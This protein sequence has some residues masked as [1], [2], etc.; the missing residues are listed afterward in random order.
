MK[1]LIKKYVFVIILLT[2]VSI[3]P[4]KSQNL[5]EAAPN[6]SLETLS[7]DTFTLSDHRDKLV[8]IFLFGYACPHCIANAPNTESG[9]YKMFQSDT[10]FIAIGIDTW[11]GS[12]NSVMS[13]Q[14]RTGLTYEM[15]INGSSVAS[16]YATTYD[17]ILVIDQEG[18][19]RYK[20]TSN[21][22]N[23]IVAQAAEVIEFLL[24][25]STG[26]EISEFAKPEPLVYPNPVIDFAHVQTDFQPGTRVFINLV[27][28]STG[29]LLL[30]ESKESDLS[31]KLL[32]GLSNYPSGS[33]YLRVV[34]EKKAQGARILISR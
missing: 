8:F 6:F 7:G 17:R 23:N 20:S 28:I 2:I 13:F 21:A 9:I 22:T 11:N 16:V 3:A 24:S 29:R 5:G 19:L 14:N 27:D 26:I 25:P 18:I 12:P 31:G 1:K 10:S 33:Y 15:C 4:V 34:N 30:N 32:I